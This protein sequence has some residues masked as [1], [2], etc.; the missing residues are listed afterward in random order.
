M[1]TRAEFFGVVNR[2]TVDQMS[3]VLRR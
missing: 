2:A 3:P 1:P